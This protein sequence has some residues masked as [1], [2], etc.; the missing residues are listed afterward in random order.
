MENP[1]LLPQL[2]DDP[3]RTSRAL[4]QLLFVFVMQRLHAH[5]DLA[6]AAI[7]LKVQK[8]DHKLIKGALGKAQQTCYCFVSQRFED[9]SLHCYAY[10]IK[11]LHNPSWMLP[12]SCG[13]TVKHFGVALLARD[14]SFDSLAMWM[15][16][17][18]T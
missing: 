1:A 13:P 16:S 6:A 3:Q 8:Q 4:L 10:P 17:T 7:A 11:A 2:T 15:Q 18:C 9:T 5:Q 12:L 14:N